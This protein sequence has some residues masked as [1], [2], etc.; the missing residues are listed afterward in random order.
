[1]NK[2]SSMRTK[3]LA[4]FGLLITAAILIETV[5]AVQSARRSVLEKI[6]AHLTDKASDTA[7]IIDG[8]ITAMFQFLEGITRLSFIQDTTVSFQD[9]TTYLKQEAQRNAILKE[10]YI[11]DPAGLQHNPKGKT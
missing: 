10:L 8:R 5:L 1:M 2:R 4:I 11:A 3:I 6:E 9:K 7:E